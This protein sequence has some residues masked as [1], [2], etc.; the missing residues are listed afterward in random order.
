MDYHYSNTA[1]IAV[2]ALIA[3]CLWLMFREPEVKYL[4]VAPAPV[5]GDLPLRVV[6]DKKGTGTH[7]LWAGRA[8]ASN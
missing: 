2:A 1:V 6:K 8:S 7:G 5:E 3:F 4:E